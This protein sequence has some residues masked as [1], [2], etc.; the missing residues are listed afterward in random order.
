MCI[1]DRILREKQ[2]MSGYNQH[3]HGASTEPRALKILATTL[4]ESCIHNVFKKALNA[5]YTIQLIMSLTK[6]QSIG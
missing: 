6:P 3:C 4:L 1:R 5:T 2:W